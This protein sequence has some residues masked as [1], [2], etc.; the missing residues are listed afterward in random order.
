MSN[1]NIGNWG[2]SLLPYV[3]QQALFD[4]FNDRVPAAF[5]FGAAGAA[6]VA[7]IETPLA[8]FMCPSAPG[9]ARDRIYNGAIPAGAVPL[10]PTLTWRAAPSDYCVPTGVRGAYSNL[11]YRGASGGSR[12]GLLQDH[13]TVVGFGQ[14]SNRS[15]RMGDVKDGTSNTFLIG[16][17][18]GGNQIYS[19]RT[20]WT[21]APDPI[22]QQLIAANGGGWGDPLNGEHWLSGTLSSGLPFPPLEGP[23]GINC[24][25]LRGYGFHSFHDAGCHFVMADGSTQFISASVDP[26]AVAGRITREKGEILPAD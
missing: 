18:T 20:E 8:A 19:L 15:A 14:G 2:I 24:T 25:N 21:L 16:E 10:L 11:A 4:K 5:E 23:C 6:N 1:I 26:L 13:I 7:I 17:R 3:E 9:N 12:H 22:R